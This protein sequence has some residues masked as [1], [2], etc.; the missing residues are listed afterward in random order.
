MLHSRLRTSYSLYKIIPNIGSYRFFTTST[1]ATAASGPFRRMFDKTQYSNY[2]EF[3]S[4]FKW[5]VPQQFNIGYACSDYH[6]QIGNGDDI[7]LIDHTSN[8]RHTYK[9][10]SSLSNKLSSSLRHQLGVINGDRISILLPQS[11]ETG[12]SHLSAFKLGAISL[13]L[14]TLFGTDALEFRL[15]DSASKVIITNE[16]CLPQILSIKHKLPHLQHIIVTGSSI[17]DCSD[18]HS[19]NTL[20]NNGSEVFNPVETSCDDPALIIYTSGTT[21]SPKGCL[22][23]HRVLLGHLPGIETPHNFLPQPGDVFWTPADW[24]WIGGLLDALLPSWFYGIPI[25]SYRAKKFDAFEAFA[26]MKQYNVTSTFLPPT[27]LKLMKMACE[28]SVH[29][30]KEKGRHSLRSIGSGGEALGDSLIEWAADTFD[31][32]INEF[33]GQTECNLV[34]SNSFNVFEAKPRSMGKPVPGHVVE[35][36]DNSG[37]VCNV[38]EIGNIAVKHP[39]PVMFLNYWNNPQKTKEKFITNAE[40]GTQWLITGDLGKKSEDGYFYFNARDDDVICSRGYR[41]GPGP[42]EIACMKHADV[43]NCAAVGIPDATTTE[44]IK[45]FVVMKEGRNVKSGH[46]LLTKEIQQLVRECEGHYVVPKYVEIVDQIPMTI[47]GKVQRGMLKKMEYEKY[48]QNN[49]V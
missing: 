22:H 44:A 43:L 38:N 41:I 2:D 33:Y 13:P 23:A 10:I 24:A 7:A 29:H 48:V 8:T 11:L 47:T 46:D 40:E 17:H 15:S 26:L 6:V 28:Q 35:I 34:V 25:V 45:V 18:Y 21:G 16:Q 3:Y 19:F 49:P 42:I 32:T 20:I 39:D 27:A 36:V 5:E 14:F 4:T 30:D 1:K 9:D 12:V 37:K 31:T